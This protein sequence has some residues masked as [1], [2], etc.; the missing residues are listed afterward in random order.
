MHSMSEF[1]GPNYRSICASEAT[2]RRAV[3]EEY[4]QRVRWLEQ[5]FEQVLATHPEPVALFVAGGM[6]REPIGLCTDIDYFLVFERPTLPELTVRLDRQLARAIEE[7][8]AP[9][10]VLAA[11]GMKGNA[12]ALEDVRARFDAD[13]TF[14]LLFLDSTQLCNDDGFGRQLDV[15][16]QQLMDLVEARGGACE[17][18][19][20]YLEMLDQAILELS[21][22][23]VYPLVP[24][25]R[26]A[27]LLRFMADT[28]ILERVV[29]GGIKQRLERYTLDLLRLRDHLELTGGRRALIARKAASRLHDLLQLSTPHDDFLDLGLELRRIAEVVAEPVDRNLFDV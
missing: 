26:K 6:V 14:R 11:L 15:F 8:A 2:Y 28:A 24:L 25:V 4:L 21:M 7:R 22:R 5:V 29:L 27:S 12:V 19:A 1:E 3:R 9:D 10:P 17:L 13:E 20:D 16:R 18:C 23:A